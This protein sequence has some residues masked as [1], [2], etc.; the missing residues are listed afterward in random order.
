MLPR[1]ATVDSY[2]ELSLWI[3]IVKY[4]YKLLES[5]KDIQTK[6][7]MA[8]IQMKDNIMKWRIMR[9]KTLT[10]AGQYEVKLKAL[11]Q[12][13]NNDKQNKILSETNNSN[14]KCRTI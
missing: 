1:T 4:N 14:K 7:M 3:A 13:K 9:K 2:C 12:V 10:S 5:G 6:P 8:L 11:I